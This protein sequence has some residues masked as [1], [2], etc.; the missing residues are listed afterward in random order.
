MIPQE[1][2]GPRVTR[3]SGLIERLI[4]CKIRQTINEIFREIPHVHVSFCSSRLKA[5]PGLKTSRHLQI[6]KEKP[7]I[8][9]RLRRLQD[10]GSRAYIVSNDAVRSNRCGSM[11]VS[12]V[13]IHL[14]T[15]AA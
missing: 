14:H 11:Q 5:H 3:D 9:K 8:A 6:L 10:K 1:V 12:G 7:E 13:H 15:S 2:Q 4:G